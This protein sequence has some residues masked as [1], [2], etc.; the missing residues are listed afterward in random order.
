MSEGHSQGKGNLNIREMFFMR[1]GTLFT[2]LFGALFPALLITLPKQATGDPEPKK[3][4][5][6]D[7]VRCFVVMVL[8]VGL[9]AHS[10]HALAAEGGSSMYIPGGAGDAVIALSPEPGLQIANALYTQ[11][12]TVDTAVLQGAVDLEIDL[13]VVLNFL[14]RRTLSKT[15]FLAEPI[16]SAWSF[17]LDMSSWTRQ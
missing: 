11:V 4:H 14:E 8:C 7:L 5:A 15:M 2:A 12:A 13:T 10:V 16:Q 1:P 17:Y 3:F 9:F 6:T